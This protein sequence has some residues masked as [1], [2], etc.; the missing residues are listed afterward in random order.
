MASP[1]DS[2]PPKA[3]NISKFTAK[4][5]VAKKM[6]LKEDAE[7]NPENYPLIQ[8]GEHA[9]WE[10]SNAPTSQKFAAKKVDPEGK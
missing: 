6:N 10:L 7:L 5:P 1:I 9:I 4:K 8:L 3:P 2:L